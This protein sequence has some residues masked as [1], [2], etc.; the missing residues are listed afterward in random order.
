MELSPY[1]KSD[2]DFLQGLLD[3]TGSQ[4][5]T[6]KQTTNCYYPMSPEFDIASELLNIELSGAPE[7]QQQQQ[8]QDPERHQPTSTAMLL[9]EG[10]P[11]FGRIAPEDHQP[12]NHTDQHQEDTPISTT[13]SNNIESCSYVTPPRQQVQPQF[14]QRLDRAPPSTKSCNCASTLLDHLSAPFHALSSSFLPPS[15]P[16]SLP[17]EYLSLAATPQWRAPTCAPRALQ[18][19]SSSAKPLIGR[20]FRWTWVIPLSGHPY[21]R[22]SQVTTMEHLHHNRLRHR[23]RHRRRH[24]AQVVVIAMTSHSYRHW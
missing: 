11:Y 20:S 4:C 16:P 24:P 1:Q 5:V 6:P 2:D 17:L 8:Q 12:R 23:R 19:R 15:Q 7:Q 3:V 21:W 13:R 9:D 18:L 14:S 22:L 10:L